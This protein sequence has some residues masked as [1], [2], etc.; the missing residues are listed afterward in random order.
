MNPPTIL[1]GVAILFVSALY[2]VSPLRKN[3][4]KKKRTFTTSAV[5][6]DSRDKHEAAMKSLR[7][8]EFDYRLGKVAEEDYS[9]LRIQLISEAAQSFP[10]SK[11]P[12]EKAGEDAL[13]A[14]IQAHK[15]SL[16]KHCSCPKCGRALM[17]SDRFCPGCGATNAVFCPKCGKRLDESSVFCSVCGTRI[18]S[19]EP[20]IE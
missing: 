2:V 11:L 4:L 15:E 17:E 13:E 6:M 1:I 18:V 14:L 10:P 12:V 5:K 8:L 19:V 3:G 16:G 9:S 7:D 20:V